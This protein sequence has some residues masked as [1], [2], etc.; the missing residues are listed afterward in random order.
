MAEPLP[1]ASPSNLTLEHDEQ[2]LDQEQA[3]SRAAKKV[4][5]DLDDAPF[6]Q[7]TPSEEKKKLSSEEARPPEKPVTAERD[8]QK[9]GKSSRKMFFI[10]G[11]AAILLL[12][13]VLTFWLTRPVPPPAPELPPAP[14]EQVSPPAPKPVEHFV[15]LE[16]FL[17]TYAHGNEI[18]FLSMKMSL[19]T[20]D[21][22]LP[23]EIRRKTI[24][25]RDAAYYFLNNR[26]LPTVKMAEAAETL[27]QDLL[28]VFNQHLSRP[29][30]GVLIE[31]FLVQ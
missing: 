3:A 1:A 9:E 22:T 8:G 4:A 31:E 21:P 17:V 14:P 15:D 5:L 7:E 23:L 16:P 25:L 19:V 11:A 30:T 26:P 29:L 10:L 27:K 18:L 24:I 13:G 28:S 20:E 12:A 6:L 2:I